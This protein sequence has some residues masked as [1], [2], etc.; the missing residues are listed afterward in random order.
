[1]KRVKRLL[2]WSGCVVIVLLGLAY[3]AMDY[4]VDRVLRSM[5]T[6]GLTNGVEEGIELSVDGNRRN[7]GQSEKVWTVGGAGAGDEPGQHAIVDDAIGQELNDGDVS[8]NS[9]SLRELYS[10]SDGLMVDSGGDGDAGTDSGTGTV[11]RHEPEPYTG[12]ITPEKIEAAVEKITFREKTKVTSILLRR[13]SA[14]DIRRLSS[15]SSMSL[16]EK[17]D[18][19]SLF[20]DKLSEEEYD[21]LIAIAAKLGLSSGQTYAESTGM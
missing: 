4:G 3:Y 1:M 8:N 15:M 19:K 9:D 17:K 6:I 12:E 20:L 18:A 16:E 14:S 13:L 21:E 5:Q 7:I 10:G 11:S 2:I